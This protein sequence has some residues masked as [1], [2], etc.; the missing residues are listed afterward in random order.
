MISYMYQGI[1]I[2][3]RDNCHEVPSL[4]R[5]FP[6]EEHA[7]RAIDL[8]LKPKP[9]EARPEAEIGAPLPGNPIEGRA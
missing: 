9:E 3:M 6:S 7:R 5:R 8:A 2:W 4:G 1:G